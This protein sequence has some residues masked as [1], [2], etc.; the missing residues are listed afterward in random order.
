MRVEGYFKKKKNSNKVNLFTKY[1]KRYFVLDVEA[2]SLS[3]SS[4]KGKP[5]TNTIMI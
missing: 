1:T 4:E 3:Y 5:F 2:G